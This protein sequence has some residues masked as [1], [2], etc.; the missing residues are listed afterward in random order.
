MGDS[1][2]EAVDRFCNLSNMLSAGGGCMAAAIARCRCAWGKFCEN[3]PLLTTLDM[4]FKICGCLFNSVKHSS[5]LHATETWQMSAKALHRLRRND[6]AM[7]GWIC[8][9]KPSDVLSIDDLHGKLG[10]WDITVAI[11]V[12]RLRWF[13]HGEKEI[14]NKINN[15]V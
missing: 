8:G 13:G 7:I 14:L 4:P 12:R 11:R 9:V 10:P 6:H 1:T 2:L 15:S 3:L 5:L